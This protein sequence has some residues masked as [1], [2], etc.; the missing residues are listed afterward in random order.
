MGVKLR[1][2]RGRGGLVVAVG[3]G[4]ESPHR[5]RPE[6]EIGG[7]P[8]ATVLDQWPSPQRDGDG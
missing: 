5:V 8:G 2:E 1:E 7:G 6:V 3:E 4:E